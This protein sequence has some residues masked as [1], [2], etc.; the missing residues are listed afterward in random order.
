M[1]V[2][3]PLPLAAQQSIKDHFV[4]RPDNGELFVV[5]LSNITLTSR[6]GFRA[7]HPDLSITLNRSDLEFLQPLRSVLFQF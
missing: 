3:Q 1:G 2:V 6:K 4:F 5:D 7:S